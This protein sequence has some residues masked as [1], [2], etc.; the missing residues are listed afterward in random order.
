MKTS[1]K[2]VKSLHVDHHTLTALFFGYFL[3]LAVT[4]TFIYTSEPSTRA[5]MA[6]Q[7]ADSRQGN[8][9]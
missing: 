5:A 1:V 9:N 4:L 7:H 2:F 6:T 3:L 8:Q